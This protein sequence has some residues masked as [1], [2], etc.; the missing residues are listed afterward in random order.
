MLGVFKKL[1]AN[2]I[3]ITP[4]EA[5]KQ[6]SNTNMALI[7]ANVTPIEWSNL[8]KALF[9]EGNRKWFQIDKLYYRDYIQNR[10]NRLELTDANY[11][12]QERRLYKKAT[13]ISFA[14]KTFGSE[15]QPTSFTV[16][17]SY[18]AS[19]LTPNLFYSIADD[20][21]GNLYN[22]NLELV[23][24][25]DEDNRVLYI[26]PVN[27][28][29]NLDLFVDNNTGNSIVNARSEYYKTITD[30]SYFSNT[31]KY[32]SCS[33]ATNSFSDGFTSI[34][35]S[36]NNP[37][38]P[39]RVRIEDESYLNFN[40]E[41]FAISFYLDRN[42]Q[43]EDS[44]NEDKTYYILSKKNSKKI[45]PEN[46]GTNVSNSLQPQYVEDGS[47]FP[48]QIYISSSNAT[49][50]I[51]FE[52]QGE[53]GLISITNN[54]EYRLKSGSDGSATHVVCQR[55]LHTDG[56]PVLQIWING[57]KATNDLS[58]GVKDKT[59]NCA[60]KSSITLFAE[61]NNDGTFSNGFPS[62]SSISQ[63]MIW[64][65]DL[66]ENHIPNISQSITGTPYVGNLFYD[67]GFGVI[68]HPSYQ[69]ALATPDI[70]VGLSSSS[71]V[72]EL[73]ELQEA[74]SFTFNDKG[75]K[76]FVVDK[77]SGAEGEIKEYH[78]SKP[79]DISSA[80]YS[81][82][83]I[84]GFVLASTVPSNIVFSTRGTEMFIV[85]AM[86][87]IRHYKLTSPFNLDGAFLH[88]EIN[89]NSSFGGG[90][91]NVNAVT[92]MVFNQ[93]G[94]KLI[95]GVKKDHPGGYSL[96]SY[97]LKTPFE[98]NSAIFN[99]ERSFSTTNTVG[100]SP[101]H[102]QASDDGKNVFLLDNIGDQII[103][104]Y[105][106]SSNQ[107]DLGAISLT[108]TASFYIGGINNDP[109]A[110]EFTN[111]Y[112]SKMFLLGKQDNKLHE[113]YSNPNLE[114]FKY[115]NTHPITEFEYQCTVKDTEFN[116]TTNMSARKNGNVGEEKL[117]DFATG[118]NFKPY[119]TSVGLYDDNGNLLLVGK[120]GQPIK[121]SEETDT[122]FVLRFD[123]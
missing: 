59:I 105:V 28:F 73:T 114:R 61:P 111:S 75:T 1:N 120:L 93:T 99:E 112:S 16:S 9:Y 37:S 42:K 7:G 49:A 45:L 121:T 78:L 77:R 118:S 6:Y 52:R 54:R 95:I 57:I 103:H 80:T 27:G 94:T 108:N 32:Y 86:T 34:K 20:G 15:V 41:N 13:L 96:H 48:Y 71:I 74:S 2:D 24:F 70:P 87:Y 60:N 66:T 23:N 116:F 117:A 8:N 4:F 107:L 68:T 98:L 119:I 88:N 104:Y 69:E 109:R 92:S 19:L 65:T 44:L 62:G 55:T 46:D 35:A 81:H 18:S 25:P 43:F 39:A 22:T 122:T 21:Y 76:L 30:D 58:T 85:N 110:I 63:L 38:D 90:P 33:F 56:T 51:V 12:V 17:S 91:S 31:V 106:T 83:P 5:H 79:F 89:N 14:Q 97:T 3:K 67:N 26:S 50:S 29:R 84:T 64:D 10:A 72:L 82:S 100:P 53:N 115:K 113:F 47:K 102:L 36:H 101:A 11:K 123:T 40:D